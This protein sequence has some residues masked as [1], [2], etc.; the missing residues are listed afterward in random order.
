MAMG[1]FWV[2]SWAIWDSSEAILACCAA[3]AVDMSK[4]VTWH[5][6]YET[7][8]KA[9]FGQRTQPTT[10]ESPIYIVTSIAP[11]LRRSLPPPTMRRG[12]SR[13]PCAATFRRFGRL[14]HLNLANMVK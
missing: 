3:M 4:T 9:F 13:L 10:S 11:A 1:E 12:T 7:G 5:Q 14:Q 8:Q 6:K 2:P